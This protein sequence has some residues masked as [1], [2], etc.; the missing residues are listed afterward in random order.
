MSRINNIKLWPIF[1]DYLFPIHF[2]IVR[3]AIKHDITPE[4]SLAVFV[5]CMVQPTV[6]MNPFYELIKVFSNPLDNMN[7]SPHILATRWLT[8]NDINSAIVHTLILIQLIKCTLV[9]HLI[10]HGIARWAV[11][12]GAL[13]RSPH[14]IKLK[15]YCQILC[16]IR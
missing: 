8:T 11:Y 2:E 7:R 12:A 1:L 3:I 5:E 6:T 15:S 4:A 9:K 10:I 13:S 14:S 16:R